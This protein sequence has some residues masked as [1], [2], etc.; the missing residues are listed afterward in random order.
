MTTV[1][2]PSPV[3]KPGAAEQLRQATDQANGRRGAERGQVVVVD[4]VAKPGVADLVQPAELVQA[5]RAPSG[6]SRR[7]NA[8]ANRVSPERLHRPGLPE[9]PG[10]G[11]DQ[12]VLAA[13]RV[14]RRS[15]RGSSPARRTLPSRRFVSTASMTVP[16]STRWSGPAALIG[17]VAL[18]VG[19]RWAGR[20]RRRGGGRGGG[21]TA[22]RGVALAPAPWRRPHNGVGDVVDRG[23]RAASAAA[24]ALAPEARRFGSG[25]VPPAA[26]S[27]RRCSRTGSR[28]RVADVQR[29][30]GRSGG[31]A[32][33]RRFLAWMAAQAR[34][35]GLRR[36]AQPPAS[37]SMRRRSW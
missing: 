22:A 27:R 35:H 6:I 7:W 10:A 4:L 1:R 13:V 5:V 15:S 36:V 33:R 17:G 18:G 29:P 12:H 20:G 30:A 3:A 24:A 21:G 34:L 31:G 37:S 9:H 26:G 8:T 32:C 11:R 19:R 23:S 14:Q 2:S 28:S 16:S 25:A